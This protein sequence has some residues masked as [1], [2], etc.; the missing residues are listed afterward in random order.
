M[1]KWFQ[2]QQQHHF[3]LNI[4]MYMHNYLVLATGSCGM[5]FNSGGICI[6]AIPLPFV[7]ALKDNE[8]P[9]G[10]RLIAVHL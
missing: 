4:Y 9:S 7:T 5:A 2:Q 8:W 6:A 3:Q 10:R 1:F